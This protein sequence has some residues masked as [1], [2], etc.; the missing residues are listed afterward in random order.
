MVFNWKLRNSKCLQVSRTFPII[1]ADLNNAVVWM[2]FIRSL[3]SKSSSS[4][5]NILVT[6][7]SAPITIVITVTFIFFPFSC[8][9]K[10]LISF[11]AFF[12]CYSV[13]NRNS[14]VY[15][16]AR[17]L[18]QLSLGLF[19]WPTLDDPLVSKNP[20]EICTSHFL[21][22]SFGLCVYHLFV[23]SNLNILHYSQG[24][25]SPHKCV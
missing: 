5:N 19:V 9:A 20:R 10:V 7:L 18:C 1:L 2:V 21:G 24:S 22:R 8:K 4:C 15:K 12:H 3:I 25:L 11:S 17:S 23:W 6:V 16:S 13:I 14:K